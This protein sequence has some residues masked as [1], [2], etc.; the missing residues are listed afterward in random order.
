MPKKKKKGYWVPGFTRRR[1]ERVAGHT[2]RRPVLT[3]GERGRRAGVA[4]RRLLP[5]AIKATA[6]KGYRKTLAGL[7]K[8]QDKIYSPERLAGWLRTRPEVMAA[9]GAPRSKYRKYPA[10]AKKMAKKEYRTYLRRKRE[11]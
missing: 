2:R 6:R 9:R 10:A 7:E 1:G 8:Y 11:R 3:T 5:K 4:R